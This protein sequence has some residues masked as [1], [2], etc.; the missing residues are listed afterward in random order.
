MPETV[1]MRG[2]VKV[3]GIVHGALNTIVTLYEDPENF[4][5]KQFVSEDALHQFAGR[6]KLVIQQQEKNSE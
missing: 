1:T 3:V 6:N 5:F 4:E 2:T